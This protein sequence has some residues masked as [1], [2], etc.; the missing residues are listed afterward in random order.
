MVKVKCT[1]CGEVAEL[2]QVHH[3]FKEQEF[4]CFL[5]YRK[6]YLNENQNL[7]IQLV[8][9]ILKEMEEA[10]ISTAGKLLAPQRKKAAS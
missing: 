8:E 2:D 6:T 3:D 7:P 9:P 1:I 10:R 5:C 4:V